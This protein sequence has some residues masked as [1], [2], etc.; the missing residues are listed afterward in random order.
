VQVAG[1]GL[2]IIELGTDMAVN[3]NPVPVRVADAS[4]QGAEQTA[5]PRDSKDH[6]AQFA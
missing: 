1:Q 6:A 2:E 5:A 4:L 3:A